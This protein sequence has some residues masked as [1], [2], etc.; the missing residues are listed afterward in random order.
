MITQ[1]VLRYLSPLSA[2]PHTHRLCEIC[3]SAGG[4]PAEH[5][6][7]QH[8]CQVSLKKEGNTLHQLREKKFMEMLFYFQINNNAAQTQQQI[9]EAIRLKCFG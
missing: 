2:F 3:L 7:D 6:P 1:R 8:P 5:T 9:P 4:H